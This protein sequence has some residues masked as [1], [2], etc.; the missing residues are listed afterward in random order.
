MLSLILSQHH[1]RENQQN[2]LDLFVRGPIRILK[3]GRVTGKALIRLPGDKVST[4]DQNLKTNLMLDLY[5][6]LS[7]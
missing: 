3:P 2:P 5:L 7:I 1:W 4:V 6:H